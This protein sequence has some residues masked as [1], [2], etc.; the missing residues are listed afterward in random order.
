MTDLL[1]AW[2]HKVEREPTNP[3]AAKIMRPL[4][5]R[6]RAEL[7]ER[8]QSIDA[9]LEEVRDWEE[10]LDEW[11]G[12][13]YYTSP[14]EPWDTPLLNW[15]KK[16]DGSVPSTITFGQANTASADDKPSE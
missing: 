16:S 8:K 5:E 2:F 1:E 4:V 15:V 7:E 12:K 13:P 6:M 9:M 11:E 14:L 10:T 3:E